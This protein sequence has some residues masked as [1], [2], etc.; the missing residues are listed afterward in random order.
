MANSFLFIPDITGFTEFVSATDIEH[1]QHI[2]SELL[3]IIVKSNQLGMEVSEVEGD[4]VMFYRFE[5]VPTYDELINQSKIIFLNF[6]NHLR[7][8][9]SQRICECGACTS[10]SSLSL[11]FI[12]HIGEIG[13]TTVLDHKKPFGADLILAHTL[14]KNA[15][16]LSEWLWS[17]HYSRV[18]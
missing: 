3:E 9:E 16:G 18:Q 11:K 5:S 2:I 8:Y 14:L 7:L 17:H 4:A 10:A 6:Q 15:I 13:F 1:G 12:S